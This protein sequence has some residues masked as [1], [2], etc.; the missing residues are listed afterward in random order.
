MLSYVILLLVSDFVGGINPTVAKCSISPELL[1]H[2]AI[3][4]CFINNSATIFLYGSFYTYRTICIPGRAL[5]L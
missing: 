3:T 2:F 5:Q 1:F 4:V